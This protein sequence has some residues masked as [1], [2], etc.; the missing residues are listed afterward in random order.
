[1]KNIHLF[2]VIGLILILTG[3]INRDKTIPEFNGIENIKIVYEMGSSK[4]NWLDGIT[5]TDPVDGDL[6]NK[7]KVSS[8][9]NMNQEGLYHVKFKVT[10]QDNN[11]KVET[12][13]VYV[14]DLEPTITGLRD[15]TVDVNHKPNYLEHVKAIDSYDQDISN[16]ITV[17]DSHVDYTT[18]GHYK[19]YYH[20]LDSNEN[21]LTVPITLSVLEIGTRVNPVKLGN[22]YILSGN[23]PLYGDFQ[24]QL[25]I[26]GVRRGQDAEPIILNEVS[27]DEKEYLITS[28]SVQ[29]LEID[30]T[31]PY[32]QQNGFSNWDDFK[33][34]PNIGG[35]YDTDTT[36]TI[37]NSILDCNLVINQACSGN[38]VNLVDE[39]DTFIL[40]YLGNWF[41]LT[42]E[43][44]M[45]V[46]PRQIIGYSFNA[47]T[48][49]FSDYSSIKFNHPIFDE[50][51]LSN[52]TLHI[53]NVFA[54]DTSVTT[55]PSF[56]TIPKKHST[57]RGQ[58]LIRYDENYPLKNNKSFYFPIESKRNEYDE[59]FYYIKNSTYS[60]YLLYMESYSSYHHYWDYLDEAFLNTLQQ[61]EKQELSYVDFFDQYG[62]HY[63]ANG[64]F[65]GNLEISCSSLSNQKVDINQSYCS[66]L[67]S[68]NNGELS[69]DT[70][71]TDSNIES[72]FSI[73]INGGSNYSFNGVEHY[74]QDLYA[75]LDTIS[76]DEEL[77]LIDFG[78]NGLVPLWEIIPPEYEHLKEEMKLVF[79]DLYQ[80]H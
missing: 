74:S 13:N 37:E 25:T 18:P 7:I 67:A 8:N 36:V 51:W 40:K 27:V 45:T 4:P 5:A 38:L 64:V 31:N 61:L 78:S 39:G 30:E 66:Q 44:T 77:K 20:I 26:N 3:C 58:Y 57:I 56:D 50:D 32:Y 69:L 65:G 54:S 34:I 49:D 60:R 68:K 2:I 6:T 22:N 19:V 14:I 28:L 75:W 53:G 79:I 23:D 72:Y 48:S 1:M 12:L 43:K 29:L 16:Q 55:S 63:I 17:D 42:N 71:D 46:P 10:D 11:R 47:L 33:L 15:L 21:S 9:I 59:A 62:T 73:K 76:N 41:N 35:I 24:L 80:N 52:I 70:N